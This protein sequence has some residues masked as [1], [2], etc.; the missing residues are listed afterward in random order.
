M[1]S[2]VVITWF[3]KVV[4]LRNFLDLACFI[5]MFLEADAIALNLQLKFC[6]LKDADGI[7]CALKNIFGRNICS[8]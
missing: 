2:E 6:N 5:L 8:T 7:E 1:E 4:R 3:A